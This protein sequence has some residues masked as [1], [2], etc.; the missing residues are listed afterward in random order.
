[1]SNNESM[2]LVKA[3]TAG[4]TARQD[5]TGQEISVTGETNTAA[6]VAQARA[7]IEAR[8]IVALRNPRDYDTVRIKLLKECK[9]PGFAAV[10]RYRKPM[11]KKDCD[12]A[13]GGCGGSGK[14]GASIC[15]KCNGTGKASACGA[16]IRF[17]ETCLRLVG[18]CAQETRVIY[19]DH[20]K[21][22]IQVC[23]VDLETNTTYATEVVVEKTVERRFVKEGTEVIG[24]RQ[25]SYGDTVFIVVATEDEMLT[26]QNALISKA[27][28]TNGERIIPRDLIDEGQF[29]ALETQFKEDAADPD[30]A[31][32]KLL[33][34][35][36]G[37]GIAPKDIAIY[38]GHD[39]AACSPAETMDLRAVYTAIKDGE[40][41][42]AD[43]LKSRTG[44]EE[45]KS[46]AKE[47]TAKVD[48]LKTKLAEK[49]KAKESKGKA[50]AA[51]EQQSIREPGDEG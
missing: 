26:K 4:M 33:D 48:A 10:A 45:E 39:V 36:A 13:T 25:N 20:D 38:L 3:P 32:K 35:L 14:I 50:S 28:R 41:S 40:V 34:A 22:I 5:A 7:T 47:T 15:M 27:L 51:P 17:I 2:A 16:S 1:M 11:G 49:A 44:T 18:N 31:K 19:D 8:S 24:T 9:R 29:L 21:R 12:Y 42:W 46:D 6:L 23:V 37:I 30:A 43:V